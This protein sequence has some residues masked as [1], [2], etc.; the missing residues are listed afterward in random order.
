MHR[1]G[2]RSALICWMAEPIQ[3]GESTPLINGGSACWVGGERQSCDW[4]SDSGDIGESELH[5][6]CCWRWGSSSD[7]CLVA[8]D[9]ELKVSMHTWRASTH[10]KAYN[11]ELYIH[12]SC[13]HIQ[14][15]TIMECYPWLWLLFSWCCRT[16]ESHFIESCY[17]GGTMLVAF[18]SYLAPT[19]L[20]FFKLFMEF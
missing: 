20:F 2:Y 6:V 4:C 11:K 10:L 18:S 3:R 17:G 14:H 19:D 12:A 1:W 5:G 8:D 15:C 13:S 16:P 9:Q 7:Y